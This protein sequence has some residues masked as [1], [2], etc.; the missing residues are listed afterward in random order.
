MFT[1]SSDEMDYHIDK[2]KTSIEHLQPE[3][4]AEVIT[5]ALN[6]ILDLI[7]MLADRVCYR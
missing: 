2:V 6:D 4:H 3:S 1:S 7:Q 5:T